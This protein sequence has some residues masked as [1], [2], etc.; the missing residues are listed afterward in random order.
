MHG[1]LSVGHLIE[2]MNA[3][4]RLGYGAGHY[5]RALEGQDMAGMDIVLGQVNPEIRSVRCA[6]PVIEDCVD[7]AFFLYTLPKMAASHSHFCRMHFRR[8]TRIRTVRRISGQEEIISN[9]FYSKS[10]FPT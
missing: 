9:I 6:A 10:W 3:H 8:N 2:D 4:M 1:I 7:P 5:F